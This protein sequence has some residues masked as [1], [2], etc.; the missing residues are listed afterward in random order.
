MN[1]DKTSFDVIVIGA[2]SGGLNIAG[3]MNRVGFRVL[4]IDKSDEHIGGDCLNFGCVPSKALIHIARMFHE[5]RKSEEFGLEVTGTADWKK[6]RG[7]IKERQVIIREHENTNWLRESGMTVVLG[8]AAFTTPNSIS[9][10]GIE[11][12]GKNIIIATG[13]RPRLISG[14][15]I[16][17]V[18][19]VLNNE[20]IFEMEELPKKLLVIGGGPIGIEIAQALALLGAEVVVTDRGAMILG[21]EDPEIAVVLMEQMKKQGVTFL[22]EHNLKEFTSGHAAALTDTNG[23]DMVVEFDAVFVGVGR[24]LNVEGLA[25][26]K[27]G[28]KMNERGGIRADE[29]LSTTNKHVFLCGDIAGGYQFTH[30]AEMHASTILR[31]FFSPI[32]KKFSADHIAWTTYTYPEIATFG[33]QESELKKRGIVYIPLVTDF[34][35]DDRAITDNYQYGKSKLFVS[36]KG[37]LLGGTMVA[38]N[39]GELTQELILANSAGVT[40]DELFAKTYPYPSAARINKRSISS[41]MAGK[42]TER[43]K[44]VLRLLYR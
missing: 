10:D 16:E 1:T 27:A 23:N 17:K 6:V 14:Q 28:I 13:S 26:E 25:L 36:P 5:A 31:N 21:K 11:Y 12:Q 4:L 41:F 30:A 15:G 35:E 20:N 3:F 37:K 39:A 18:S 38:P 24:E 8:S 7:Y 9:V 22:M 42:L 34:H 43:A 32:K 29:Y 19:R 33:L 44:W 2:G 40:V